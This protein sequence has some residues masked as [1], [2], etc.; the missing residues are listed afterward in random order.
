M[1]GK[2]RLNCE[3]RCCTVL[4]AAQDLATSA[5]CLA[6]PGVLNF[7][8]ARNP[9]GGFT[10]GAEAQEESLAR[11]SGLYPCLTK[12][13]Q[14]FFAPHRQ[15]ASGL[16]THGLIH[17]PQVPVVRDEHGTLLEKPYLI[18]FVTAAAPNCGVLKKKCST[19]EAAS[20]CNAA[21]RERIQ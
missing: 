6:A 5:D 4:A 14:A 17:S 2:Q 10:T 16:Y 11:S 21:L 15:A 12:H 13:F 8:S 20:H 1:V 9:G 18:D 3:V 19:Q 7:A